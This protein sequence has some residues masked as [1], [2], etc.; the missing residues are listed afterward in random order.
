MEKQDLKKFTDIM[1]AIAENYPGTTFTSNGLKLRFEALREFSIDQISEAA[2]KLIRTHK[3]NSMPTTADFIAV[4]D[5]TLG[6]D[7][8]EGQGR[9]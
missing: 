7:Q 9:N 3:Y 4:I 6:Q 5:D 8:R 1:M 2:V